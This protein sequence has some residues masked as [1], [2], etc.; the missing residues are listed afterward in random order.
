MEKAGQDCVELNTIGL[1]S[2][3][4]ILSNAEWIGNHHSA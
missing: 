2:H 3:R 4:G 1:K